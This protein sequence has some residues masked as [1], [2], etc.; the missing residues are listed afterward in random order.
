MFLFSILIGVFSVS[1]IKE[2]DY[3]KIGY[4]VSI[5]AFAMT[6]YSVILY[7]LYDYPL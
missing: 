1:F 3:K 4:A 6:V 7:N 2:G 5:S